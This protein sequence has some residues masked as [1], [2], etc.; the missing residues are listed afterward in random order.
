MAKRKSKKTAAKTEPK[1]TRFPADRLEAFLKTVRA[2]GDRTAAGKALSLHPSTLS[3]YLRDDPIF[4]AAVETAEDYFFGVVLSQE[5]D[6]IAAAK[7]AIF[8]HISGR[9]E[10]VK[11]TVRRKLDPET[12][13]VLYLEETVTKTVAAPTDAMLQKF[14][15]AVLE[16][17]RLRVPE[18]TIDVT[19]DERL[20]AARGVINSGVERHNVIS[21]TD[22]LQLE[23][24]SVYSGGED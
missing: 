17:V 18:K 13:E 21:L 9:A 23:S 5:E 6:L 7:K 11:H 4:A 20:P 15:P 3:K 22:R 2:T 14:L 10:T 16:H 19:S 24:A 8:D 1:R 12:H